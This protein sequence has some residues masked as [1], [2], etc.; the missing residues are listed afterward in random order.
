MK[1]LNSHQQVFASNK[2]L[3]WYLLAILFFLFFVNGIN[4]QQVI[5]SFPY[6]DGGFENQTATTTISGT[7]S[8]TAWTVSSTGNST[9]RSIINDAATA[10]TGAKYA[11][12][13]TNTTNVR[14][15]TPNTSTLANAPAPNTQY[16]VQFYY[17][18]TSDPS[19]YMQGGIY[20][21]STGTTNSKN[22]SVTTTYAS[23]VWT[24]AY[25]TMTSNTDA[26]A[27]TN[28]ACIRYTSATAA[29]ML[30]DDYV[31][32]PGTLDISAPDAPTTPTTSNPSSTSITLSWTAPGTGVDN[33]GYMVVRG[34][35]DPTTTPNANGIYAQGNTVASNQTV[36]YIG[37]NTTYTDASLATGTKYY[38]RI[39]TVDK[40]FNYSA[41]LTTNAY[42]GAVPSITTNAAS[43]FSTT[44]A[45]FN[46]N[47]SSDGGVTLT[48]RGFCYKA[49]SP[50]SISDNKT[51]ASG[52]A[53][54]AY[55]NPSPTLVINTQLFYKAYATNGVGTT[56]GSESSFYT[57]ADVPSA[58]TLS[59]AISSSIDVAINSSTNPSTTQFAIYETSTSQYVQVDGTLGASAAWQTA[60]TWGTKTVTG[61]SPSTSYTFEVKARNGDNTE[62][63]LGLPASLSTSAGSSPT[64]SVGA[65]SANF[66]NQCL[67]LTAGPSNFTI[68]GSVLTSADVT[69]AALTG[70]TYSTTSD[71]S[72]PYTSTLSLP[73]AG[74]AFSQVVYVKF[75]PTV[76]Q[77][78]DGN[79]VVSG[80]GASSVNR[81][82]T[83]SGI[84]T[85][86]TV[87]TTSPATLITNTTVTLTGN[88]S[89]AG[90]QTIT[91][92]GFC[93]GT[94]ASPDLTGSYTTETG[95]TGAVSSN[96]SGLTA[97]TS[98]HFRAY[99][100]S[101]AGTNYGA[102]ATFSTISN[103]PAAQASSLTFTNTT[104]TSY[105]VTFTAASGGAD[106]YLVLRGTGSA[107]TGTP[108]N[109]T[110]Y[111]L[112]QTNIGSGTNKVAYVGSAI[113]FNE[114]G[115]TA[116]TTY[117]Y[118]IYSYN[119]TTVTASYLTASPLS[120]NTSTSPLTTL[121]TPTV[122]TASK[123]TLTGFTANWTAVANATSYAI[124]VYDGA[125]A[126]VSGSPKTVN[127]ASSATLA[128]TG[129]LLPN[130]S[131]TYTVTA[132]GD[133]VN[134][135]AS[136][137]ASGNSASFT[138]AT[139]TGSYTIQYAASDVATLLADLNGG[140]ADIYELTSSGGA[141]TFTTTTT[142]SAVLV[143]N[144]IVRAVAGLASKPIIKVNTS[145]TGTT[146][147]MFQIP[148]TVT[149][150]TL[151]FDGLE[152]DGINPGN[153][154]SGY[155][156]PN[157]I[158]DA[159]TGTTNTQLYVTNCYFHDFLNAAG[160]GVIRLNG[161]AGTQTMDVQ[162]STFNNC[163]GRILYPNSASTSPTTN[164]NLKNNTFSN[165]VTLA[166]SRHNIIYNNVANP[167]TTTI[168][169]CTFYKV[170]DAAV[171][172]GIVS[173]TGSG[174]GAI[175][176]K[177]SIF[178]TAPTTL[179][180]ATVD[181]CYLAGLQS[182][183]SG[184]SYTG[185]TH[186]FATAPTFTNTTS[187]DFSLT[188]KSSFTPT[189]DG[190]YYAGNTYYTLAIPGIS[191]GSSPAAVGFT[192]NW[193][194]VANA[195][196]YDVKVYQGA[197]WIST[198]NASGQ[199]TASLAITGLSGNTA[200]T[201]TVTAKGD[202]TSYFY[203]SKPSV[204]SASISTSNAFTIT[205][206]TSVSSL[207]TL[208]SASVVTVAN[209]ATLTL[210]ANTTVNSLT[211]NAGGKLTLNNTFTLS[212][213]SL[214]LQNIA[215]ASASFVDSNSADIPTVVSATVN[216]N[217]AATDR[218]WYVSV[219]VSGKTTTALTFGASIVS[220]D[221]LNAAWTTLSNGD[222]LVPGVG[223]IATA[224][225][226]GT[227][228]WSV[229]GNLNS[230]L[231]Q[232]TVTASSTTSYIG[233]NL[234][235]NPYPSYLNWSAVLQNSTNAS[236]LQSTIWYRTKSAGTYSFQTYNAS[237]DLG[238]PI[239]ASGYIPPMQAFW[240][241][242]NT[243][244]GTVT[245]NNAMRSHGDGSA[246]MLKV[247]A[248][249]KS[250]QP[251]LRIVV[252]NLGNNNSD[253]AVVY[254]NPNASNGYDAYDSQKMSNANAAIPEIY[255][256]VNG[257]NLV[258][259]GLNSIP[260]NTELP[261][262]FSTG[263]QNTF[264]IKASQLSNFDPGTQ[265]ILKDNVL[266][267]ETDLT[268]G[269]A[270]SF[271]SD[272]TNTSTR[273]SVL[274]KSA[275]LTTG[276]DPSIDKLVSV[277]R[278]EQNQIAVNYYGNVSHAEVSVYNVAGQKLV[279]KQLSGTTTI[280]TTPLGSGVYVVRVTK[281]GI[282]TTKEVIL[283]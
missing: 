114:T 252:Q 1:K 150:L 195:S 275:S 133:N 7:L 186:T 259:N 176:I 223:Y 93:Y 249:N 201:Y 11:S 234:L 157:A 12:H 96:I 10:R 109:A 100:T 248:V 99:A 86:A 78:Y 53:T 131:Y 268:N 54:G 263:Q 226:A 269:S 205:G 38:Y 44:G 146:M 228:T 159:N 135:Y 173:I 139:S 97:A 211:V 124:N 57:L 108:V 43:A 153:G 283:N 121:D 58:P 73:S 94:S 160:N 175:T 117:Y 102:D 166:T 200:Y 156:Q 31:V 258:I 144:T 251:T 203:D 29:N 90:C 216:Q 123:A 242:A 148:T 271:S 51:V 71:G 132:I 238:T 213:P 129:L 227:T 240:V 92:R 69:V 89:D 134:A 183:T 184:A 202:N 280:I 187:L 136:S 75:T 208:N 272:A 182:G 61:L 165:T 209:G 185:A 220:R 70:F 230:G 162:G 196:S 33:G 77:A 118:T 167:G 151:R 41:A 232:P 273:F 79:I 83:G 50:V 274:F 138:T 181:Y 219:P 17:K 6:M 87:S 247:K 2:A 279:S 110:S 65:L 68:T 34:T 55:S 206:A 246:N 180:T 32:Y 163:G 130:T 218:N 113:T 281:A 140:A 24:K 105:T 282:N 164:I 253:E 277:Y 40:A 266:G 145:G 74:G 158:Y 47:I 262:G 188:N 26:V 9:V 149:G 177:N 214:I 45:T 244:G 15:Q 237:G 235:G 256:S 95:S 28:F 62:T 204:A 225:T 5:G 154:G 229:S 169:H 222:N 128:I 224:S 84:N 241:L 261:L 39:Y 122:G 82:V 278:N 19:S 231:V 197:S 270:Y 64:L 14:L 171:P 193:T 143:R 147:S 243:G 101:S 112:G 257:Q 98:Y 66:G 170:A 36:V 56:L 190:S 210:N 21:V 179:P 88:V 76:V 141:Y 20:N 63:A 107:P 60:S 212:T 18:T 52:T 137:A 16:T 126:L 221:E 236:I 239:N 172:N 119:G 142:T 120:G 115:L 103:P 104:T 30:I 13:T 25:A 37:P 255:T 46:G 264:S 245:F 215:S 116:N 81:S 49:T 72:I 152:F 189:L 233:Y 4:A 23:G 267:T 80:G 178:V 111:T 174:N 22:L 42:A 260:M 48:E 67:N 217:I 59:G 155:A 254:F 3:Y 8:T 127:G 85:L 35:A 198:T 207:T 191:A 276:I 168:D 125:S 192:A 161:S 106:N 265:L 194:A 91:A 250:L 199:A 27:S